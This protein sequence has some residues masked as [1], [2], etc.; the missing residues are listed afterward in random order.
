MSV[1]QLWFLSSDAKHLWR[2][3]VFTQFGICSDIPGIL[4]TMAR[5]GAVVSIGCA[6]EL[7]VDTTQ[8]GQQIVVL[9]LREPMEVVTLPEGSSREMWGCLRLSGAYTAVI[10][11][12]ETSSP[13][14]MSDKSPGTLYANSHCEAR[15][16]LVAAVAYKKAQDPTGR[17]VGLPRLFDHEDREVS[18]DAEEIG[19]VEHAIAIVSSPALKPTWLSQCR[20]WIRERLGRDNC[21]QAQSAV[22]G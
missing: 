6:A 17:V 18:V 5:D 7:R 19:L 4:E 3:G 10:V 22:V 21:P 11:W 14:G 20:R 8:F 12:E 2:E 1:K 13:D 16:A 9:T 15:Q